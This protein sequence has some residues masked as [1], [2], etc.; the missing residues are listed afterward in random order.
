MA[1]LEKLNNREYWNLLREIQEVPRTI[2]GEGFH[3][4]LEILGKKIPI[5][6]LTIPTGTQCG[7]WTI[8]EEWSVTQATLKS[9]KNQKVLV[10]GK[11]DQFRLWQ[12]STSFGGVIERDTLINE[13]L[14][15]LDHCEKGVP[16]IITPYKKRWG[17][18]VSKEFLSS[19]TEK[20]YEV[21]IKTE[22][23]PGNLEIGVATL[24]GKSSK[25]ILID[26]ILGLGPLANNLS[27]V[28]AA[29]ALY[30]FLA[31]LPNRKYTYRFLFTPETIGPIALLYCHTHI[32]DSVV[33]GINLQNLADKGKHLSLKYSR[34]GTTPVDRALK[35]I[36]EYWKSDLTT[37]VPLIEPYHVMASNS[38]NEKAYNSLGLDIP[39]TSF[40]R[41]QLGEYPEYDTH[42]DDMNWVSEPHFIDSL[43]ALAAGFDALELNTIPVHTFKGEPFLT[44]YGLFPKIEKDVDRIPYNFL[45]AFSDGKHDLIDIAES[46]KISVGKFR[47]ALTLMVEKGLLLLG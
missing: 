1:F 5:E 35:H 36:V 16:W 38:G 31:S 40:R 18:S 45:M 41:T 29:V 8:P 22:F 9:V 20:E 37:A 6:I 10:D 43:R 21:D 25:T 19:L 47:E 27:G 14:R 44:G 39:M 4:S 24:E 15:W 32:Y 33:G 28:V 42:L 7:S 3:K 13:H 17:F 34:P 23:R 46:A 11:K 12:Y 2:M 30:D 26:A